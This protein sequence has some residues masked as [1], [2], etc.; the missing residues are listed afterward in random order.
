MRRIGITCTEGGLSTDVIR[1]LVTRGDPIAKMLGTEEWLDAAKWDLYELPTGHW[2]M[3]TM[4]DA[5]VDLL[6]LVALDTR[7]NSE[8]D[9]EP[10]L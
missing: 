6:H 5:L 1:R 8:Q 7:R 9:R 10:G 3:L 2:A 4:P